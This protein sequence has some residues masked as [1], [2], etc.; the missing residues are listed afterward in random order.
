MPHQRSLNEVIARYGAG[1]RSAPD[2]APRRRLPLPDFARI[3][4][5]HLLLAASCALIA[6]AFTPVAAHAGDA[7]AAAP[8]GKAAA[9]VHHSVMADLVQLDGFRANL[10]D[11]FGNLEF[12]LRFVLSGSDYKKAYGLS[13]SAQHKRQ[14]GD[15]GGARDDILQA[16]EI[17]LAG[18]D[19]HATAAEIARY[20]PRA[21]GDAARVQDYKKLSPHLSEVIRLSA[22]LPAEPATKP[23][24][25][26]RGGY[27]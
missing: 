22:V 11:S 6:S 21:S 4:S 5:R 25:K 23:A 2:R 15:M 27:N 13:D 7:A 19:G 8:A 17:I 14:S 16:T 3:D 18:V 1:P 9:T 20:W 24:A 10:E 26:P 12:K